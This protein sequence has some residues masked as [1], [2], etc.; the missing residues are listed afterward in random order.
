MS[1]KTH[2][3]LAVEPYHLGK[4]RTGRAV[5]AEVFTGSSCGPCVGVDR[6][7]DAVI[8]R[9]ERQD[10]VVLMH[11]VHVPAPDPL[12]NRANET[13]EKFY[14]FEDA[15]RYFIDGV[16][17]TSAGGGTADEAA[18][19]LSKGIEP[20]LQDELAKRPDARLSLRVSTRAGSVRVAVTADH[21]K[22]PSSA[23]R[24]H[25]SASVPL[26]TPIACF[27]PQYSARCFSNRS[28]RG[29]RMKS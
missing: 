4:S 26:E 16:Q 10:V 19:I 15:P 12:A 28:T 23:I 18:A 5:L 11:H 7:F 6:A 25:S 14:G 22:Q 17:P 21:I 3:R 29:P 2:P 13:R 1:A 8:D 9:Y 20:A 24:L 27:V